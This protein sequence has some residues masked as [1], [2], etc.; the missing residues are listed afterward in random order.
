[1]TPAVDHARAL[2][3]HFELHE[4]ASASAGAWG[5]EAARALGLDPE[6][7]FKTLIARL[8]GGPLVVAIVPVV[9][10]LDL[11]KLA[12]AA[13]AKRAELADARDAERSTGYV[14]GGI[15]PLGQRR[16]LDTFLDATAERH[17]TVYVSAGRRGLEIELAPGD[18]AAAC[19]A[20]IAP[21]AR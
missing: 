13:G 19:S 7:V 21:L 9:G 11:K 14:L 17:P 4:Y 8:V 15:S 6:R 18:L 3:L 1:M 20:V 16:A 2:G 12:G 10:Q 5:E